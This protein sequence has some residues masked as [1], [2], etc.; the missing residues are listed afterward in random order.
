MI[1]SSRE[2][3]DRFYMNKKVSG[4]GLAIILLFILIIA[5]VIFFLFNN[6]SGHQA[7]EA[8]N[9]FYSYEQDG[10]YAE[11]WAMFHPLMQEKFLKG[12]YI[13]DRAHVFMNHFGVTSFTYSL[14]DVSEVHNWQMDEKSEKIDHAYK[15]TVTQVFKGKYGNFMIVQD[16]Y[17]TLMDDQWKVLW[18]YNL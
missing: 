16:V 13:E 11:S 7:E 17:V 1:H 9:E 15:V 12:D 3:G 8:V 18:D 14:D 10:S 4:K 2:K 6:A 5:A